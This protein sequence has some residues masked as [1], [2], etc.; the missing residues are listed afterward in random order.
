MVIV[1]HHRATD[2]VVVIATHHR[3]TGS[4]ELTT[5]NDDDRDGEGTVNQCNNTL[6]FLGDDEEK[7]S[8]WY[9]RGN[10][11]DEVEYGPLAVLYHRYKYINGM[12]YRPLAVLFH[13]Y[14]YTNRNG[15]QTTGSPIPQLQIYK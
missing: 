15:I 6:P 5:E 3:A 8:H 7:Y 2:V 4:C 12:E 14:K 10:C 9:W 11:K 13:S 1:T